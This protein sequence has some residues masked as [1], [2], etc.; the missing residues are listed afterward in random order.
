MRN[1]LGDKIRVDTFSR[2]TRTHGYFYTRE[3]NIYAVIHIPP[4][5]NVY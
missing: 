5:V 2:L 1:N 3:Q 4:H